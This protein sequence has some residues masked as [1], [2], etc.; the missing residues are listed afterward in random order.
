VKSDHFAKTVERGRE[1]ARLGGL[2]YECPYKINPNGC[3]RRNGGTW[4][5]VW[6]NKWLKGYYEEKDRQYRIARPIGSPT[7]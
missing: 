5:A 2:A 7:S 4:G 1:H 3:N 6:R